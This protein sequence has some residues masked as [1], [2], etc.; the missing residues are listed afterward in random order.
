[1]MTFP[2]NLFELTSRNSG[3]YTDES[4]ILQIAKMSYEPSWFPI[5][6]ANPRVSLHEAVDF[7]RNYKYLNS[8]TGKVGFYVP[9]LIEGT[10]FTE[11][12][13]SLPCEF[14]LHGYVFDPDKFS[15]AINW[16]ESSCNGYTYSEGIDLILLHS[17]P[18]TDGY[19]HEID[20]NNYIS[21]NLS[22]P[23][24]RS[25]G[26]NSYINKIKKILESSPD[27]DTVKRAISRARRPDIIQP[28]NPIV[29]FIAGS[30]SLL[31]ERNQIRSHLQQ[32]SNASNKLFKCLTYEDFRRDFVDGGRQE[33]YNRYIETQTDYALFIIDGKVGGVT[34]EEFN[35]ALNAYKQY[36]KP[37]IFVYYRR[38]FSLFSSREAREIESLINENGQYY[39][40]YSDI[41]ELGHLV[42]RDFINI[43]NNV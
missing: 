11:G 5:I 35:R 2:Y 7:F 32:V 24:I 14:E 37:K 3:D 8:R 43:A 29:I 4:A 38:I 41:A 31:N 16:L 9:G 10:F 20:F 42:Y 33:D 15:S 40:Q 21:V 19:G 12:A 34:Y 36:G 23:D 26:V 18:S 28:I 22:D 27:F 6:L 17:I 1:M 39:T 30:T 13:L 25:I